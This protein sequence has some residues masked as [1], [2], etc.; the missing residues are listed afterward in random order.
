MCWYILEPRSKIY[1]CDDH[2]EDHGSCLSDILLLPV[3]FVVMACISLTPV[4]ALFIYYLSD[5]YTTTKKT[6]KTGEISYPLLAKA[7]IFVVVFWLCVFLYPPADIEIN[8][9]PVTLIA[10]MFV[11]NH[12]FLPYAEVF[13]YKLRRFFGAEVA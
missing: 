1:D 13:I 3:A 7:G 9:I 2:S 5:V 4:I 10:S 12:T 8:L 6:I 11:F